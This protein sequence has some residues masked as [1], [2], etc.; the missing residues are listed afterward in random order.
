VIR[1]AQLG[2]SVRVQVRGIQ[3]QGSD[4]KHAGNLAI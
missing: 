3:V 2:A 1:E 4:V